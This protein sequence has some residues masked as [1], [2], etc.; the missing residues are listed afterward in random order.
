MPA[1]NQGKVAGSNAAGKPARFIDAVYPAV[2][3]SFGTKI[4][5]AGDLCLDMKE[6][7]YKLHIMKNI[8]KNHYKKLFFVNDRL[9]GFILIGDISESQKLTAAIKNGTAYADLVP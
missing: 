2:M 3:N 7:D 6:G 8:D 9:V 4:F 5:S 1:G